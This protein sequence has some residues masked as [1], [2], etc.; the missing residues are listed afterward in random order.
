VIRYDQ[1]IGRLDWAAPQDHMC[2]REIIEGG[3]WGGKNYAGTRHY[4]DLERRLTYE[5]LVGEHQRLTVVNFLELETLWEEYRAQG[6]CRRDSPFRPVLQGKPGNVASYR[7]HAGMYEDVGVRLADYPVVGVGSVC[8]LQAEPVIR[9]LARGLSGLGLN[10]HWFGLKLSGL[11][12]VWPD[13]YSCDSAAWSAAAR[14]EARLPGCTHVRV[15][16]RYAGQ[17]STCANCPRRADSWACQVNNLIMSL[18]RRGYQDA[19][20]SLDPGAA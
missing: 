14:R 6:E 15:R 11:P 7:R 13:I 17:P 9:H 5:E 20:F 1:E 18:E 12:E 10:L 19:L 2:E 4:L 16:G 8:R 3:W